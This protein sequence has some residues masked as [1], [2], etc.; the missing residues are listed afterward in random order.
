MLED[1]LKKLGFT[2]KE[3][4]VYT[5]LL[6]VGSAKAGEIAKRTDINRTTVYDILGL[7][8]KKGLV[9]QTKKGSQTYFVALDPARLLSYIDRE[10]EDTREQLS[11][12]KTQI[13][14]LLP[15]LQSLTHG[16]SDKPRVQF[17][18]GEKGMREAYEDTLSSTQ[19]IL[20][21][22]NV[23]TMHEGLPNFFPTYYK[24]RAKANVFIRAILPQNKASLERMAKD[25]EEMRR[26]RFLPVGE[27]FSPE[28]NIYNNKVLIMSW[29]EK[30]AVL[31]ESKE[32]ADFHRTIFHQLWESLQTKQQV[33]TSS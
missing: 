8:S 26:T 3:T 31:I 16:A 30:M 7:L 18:E 29:R 5:S 32:F 28:V 15:E 11:K 20:A 21:Y 2:P 14:H 4:R 10:I 24:R 22:A 25:K 9:S 23:A 12:Q 6:S 13:E 17:F 19:P 27:T 33:K 1:I